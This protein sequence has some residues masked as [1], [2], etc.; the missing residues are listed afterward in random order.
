MI[1]LFEGDCEATPHRRTALRE[2]LVS[3]PR[4]SER[5]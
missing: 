2:E 3:F 1:F 4:A 5:P